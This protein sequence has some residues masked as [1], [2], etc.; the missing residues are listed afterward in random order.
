MPDSRIRAHSIHVHQPSSNTSANHRLGLIQIHIAAV[1]AGFTGLFGKFLPDVRPEVITLGRTL[2]GCLALGIVTRAMGTS[3]RVRGWRDFLILAASGGLLAGH[4]ITFFKAIQVSTVAV[5]LLALSSYPLFVTFLEPLL[6]RERL[7]LR[8]IG[9]A[10]V[11]V[12]GLALVAG[13]LDMGSNA[14]RGVLWGVFSGLLCSGLPLLSRFLVRGYS[15]MTVTFYQQGTAALF[16]LP[17]VLIE[18]P[19]V[20][21]RTLALLAVLGV[22]LTALLHGLI[23]ASLRHLRAQTV[24]IVIGLEPVYGILFAALLL[25]EVPTLRMIAGGVLICAA[26]LATTLNH[27]SPEPAA[28]I[29]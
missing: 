14:T 18:R 28:A 13:S 29:G 17:V 8:D 19:V 20:S 22:V 16:V 24:S 2:I 9:A 1:L 21:G 15:S 27:A 11:V 4:W 26:V 7:R 5:G 6:F 12:A 25:G 3:L 10:L 23:V